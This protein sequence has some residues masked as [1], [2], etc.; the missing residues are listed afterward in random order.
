MTNMSKKEI[1]ALITMYIGRGQYM[2][3]R[4]AAGFHYDE[5]NGRDTPIEYKDPLDIA[6]D[7]DLL[8]DVLDD[9]AIV[10]MK[11][12]PPDPLDQEL[13]LEICRSC[14]EYHNRIK[15]CAHCLEERVTRRIPIA[16][17]RL[18]F[19]PE[20]N[21]AELLKSSL[22]SD[23]DLCRPCRNATRDGSLNLTE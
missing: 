1:D 12:P 9:D 23:L 19:N 3:T 5:P 18:H 7:E 11:G 22:F 10:L 4:N 14:A 20:T 8:D 16:V 17:A 6:P 2:V 13:H 21:E 15:L